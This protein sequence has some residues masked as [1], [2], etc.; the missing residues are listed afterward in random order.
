M[1][2]D[3]QAPRP[4]VGDRRTRFA[5][6]EQGSALGLSTTMRVRSPSVPLPARSMTG[7]ALGRTP[8]AISS[9]TLARSSTETIGYARLIGSVLRG[10]P[11]GQRKDTSQ[12]GRHSRNDPQC[13]ARSCPDLHREPQ[14]LSRLATRA[15]LPMQKQ[16]RDQSRMPLGLAHTGPNHCT[17]VGKP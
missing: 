9:R 6:I 16:D 17:H 2:P 10:V 15:L 4:E 11:A 7:G 14:L 5:Q 1:D 8:A 13:A 12:S 3:H